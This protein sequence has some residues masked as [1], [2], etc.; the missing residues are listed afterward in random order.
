MYGSC[1]FC[2]KA[3]KLIETT[4]NKCKCDNTF[5]KKHKDIDSH[6]CSFNFHNENS[7]NLQNIL[8]PIVADKIIKF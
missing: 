6:N 7:S 2:N 8:T 5:C 4:T 3:L 1:H